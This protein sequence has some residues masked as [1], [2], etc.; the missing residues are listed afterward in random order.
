M[1]LTSV[2]IAIVVAFI[3]LIVWLVRME[4]KTNTNATDIEDLYD[5]ARDQKIHP[6]NDELERRFSGFSTAM[7]EMRTEMRQGFTKISDRL[8]RILDK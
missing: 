3:G 8:D 1:E 4:G 5:H 6:N 2:H 7:G